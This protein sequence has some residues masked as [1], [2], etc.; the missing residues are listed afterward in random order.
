MSDD[1]V[2]KYFESKQLKNNGIAI[3][4]ALILG[5]L[6]LMGIG[7]IYIGKIGKG[8]AY[9]FLGLFLLIISVPLSMVFSTAATVIAIFIYLIIFV[10]TIVSVNADCNQFN[11]YFVRTKKRLW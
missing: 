5:L 4:F 7:H 2:R 1:D 8:I 10:G 11:E 9:L 6:G 3:V